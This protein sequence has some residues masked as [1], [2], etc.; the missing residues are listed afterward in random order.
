MK[1]DFKR[2]LFFFLPISLRQPTMFAW[3]YSMIKSIESIYR[4]FTDQNKVDMIR[5]SHNSQ[6]CYLQKILNDNF[7][8]GVGKRRIRIVDGNKYK[9]TYIYTEAEPKEMKYL[10][11][12]Y[13]REEV[14]YADTGVDFIVRLPK[15][16]FDLAEKD[17]RKNELQKVRA[18]VDF[19]RLASKRYKLEIE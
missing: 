4:L 2:L 7:D 5:L 3:F 19:Y 8:S 18:I 6:V 15:E 1:V 14:D 10:G 11:D 16:K 13:I 12:M 9:R 17:I